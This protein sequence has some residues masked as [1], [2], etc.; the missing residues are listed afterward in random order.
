M[1][2][3]LNLDDAAKLLKVSRE[4]LR[5]LAITNQIPGRKFGKCWGFSRLRLEGLY[6][7]DSDYMFRKRGHLSPRPSCRKSTGKTKKY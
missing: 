3:I 4:H 1:D 5:R 2:E 6:A 7:E